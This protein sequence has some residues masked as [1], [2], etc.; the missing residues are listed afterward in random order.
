MEGIKVSIV[1]PVYKVEKYL[2]RCLNSI[3]NQ[4]Y[5]NLEIILVDD[6]SP[7]GCPKMCDIWSLKD[8]RIHVIHKPVNEGLGMARNSGMDMATGEYICFFDSDDYISNDAIAKCVNA[9]QDNIADVVTFGLYNVNNCGAIVGSRIPSYNKACIYVG[10][11]VR[12]ELLPDLIAPN[13][14]QKNPPKL[15]M[16]AW[17]SMYNLPRIREISWRFVS[18]RDIISEDV[19]SLLELYCHIERAVVLPEGLYF[20]CENTDS[21]SHKY[22][23]NR[24][25]KVKAFYAACLELCKKNKYSME[26]IQRIAMPFLVST[27]AALKQESVRRAPLSLRLKNIRNVSNDDLLQ[28]VLEQHKRDHLS[29]NRKILFWV[30]R[31][32]MVLL[33]W[34]L[35]RAKA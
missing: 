28:A 14:N 26:V 1:V 20:Y 17:A 27:I 15:C 10:D 31:H 3:V 6:C 21:L 12:S 29:R 18:E 5:S 25:S 34:M 35:L 23:E 11:Q 9:A 22:Q 32:K 2:D 13:P 4:T 8:A 24:Y 33:A 16:S 30:L 19:Y 7:D